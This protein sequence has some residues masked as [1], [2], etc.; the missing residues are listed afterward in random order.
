MDYT[1][2]CTLQPRDSIKQLLGVDAAF[3]KQVAAARSLPPRIGS[4]A[5]CRNGWKITT[6]RNLDIGISPTF[7][8]HRVIRSLRGTLSWPVRRVSSNSGCKLKRPHGMDRA[9]IIA[10]GTAGRGNLAHENIVALLASRLCQV[11]DNHPPFQIDGN[12]GGL[13]AG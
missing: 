10:L 6:N 1:H 11:L 9:W 5:S 4:T 12:F 2:H 8:L 7:A 3:R 13:P